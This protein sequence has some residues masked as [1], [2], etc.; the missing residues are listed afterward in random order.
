MTK[1]LTK[2]LTNPDPDLKVVIGRTMEELLQ[3]DKKIIYLDADLMRTVATRKLLDEYPAQVFNCGIAEQN[4]IGTAAGLST[5]GFIPF[6][7]S[8]GCFN[9]RRVFDQVFMCCAYAG[10]NVK[11][12]GSDPGATSQI[13]GGTHTANEDIALYNEYVN[14]KKEKRFEESDR[15]RKMLQEKGI[16]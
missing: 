8:F 7:H 15:I 14:L 4:M 3:K 1:I 12:I 16:Y 11:I 9:S 5:E 13:N 10:T 6:V 2:P